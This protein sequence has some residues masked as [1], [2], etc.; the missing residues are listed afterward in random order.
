MTNFEQS[1]EKINLPE[2]EMESAMFAA[3]IESCE[4]AIIG[5]N[6]DGEILTWNKAAERIFG[7]A[8]DEVIGKNSLPQFPAERL[9]EEEEILEKVKRG[10][11]IGRYKSVRKRKDGSYISVSLN[12]SPIKNSA[13]EIIGVSEFVYELSEEKQLEENFP[14]QQLIAEAA[15]AQA[16]KTLQESEERYRAFIEHSGEG[17]WRFDLIEP[18]AVGLPFDEQIEFIY[19]KSFIAECNNVK[20]R[21]HGF[22]AAEE[23]IGRPLS[24]VWKLSDED[25]INYLGKFIES[26]Y[27]LTNEEIYEKSATGDDRYFLSNLIGIV[28]NDFL[29]GAW[30][31][32]RDVTV[33]RQAR[34]IYLET[35]EQLR[36]SQKVEAIGRLAGGVAHDFNNFLAVIMLHVDM[37][38]LQLSPD[39]PLRFRI[40]E[41]KTVTNKAAAMVRQLLAFGRKQALQ[42]HP[43]ILN[44]I[45]REFIKILRPLIGE[46]IEV[47]LDL[48]A[49]LGVCFVD[50]DQMTQ[51]LMNLA[52]NARDAMPKGGVLKIATS[53]IVLEKQNLK[54]KTQ[55]V[56]DY[57]CLT[58]S[59]SGGGMKP[60]TKKHIFEPFFTTKEPN[61]GTGLGLAT[62][63][64]VIKQSNGFIWVE[65]EPGAGATFELQ[66]PR[67]DQKAKSLVKEEKSKMQTGSETILLVEDA[68][69]VRRAAV[70]VL[71]VLGYRVFEA[72]NGEQAIHIAELMEEP[73][74]LLLTDIVMPR[75]NG[76]ELAEQIKIRHPETAVLYMSGYDDDIV[77]DQGVLGEDVHFLNKPFSPL[78]LAD[79]VR[80]VLDK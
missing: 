12:I 20:A 40:E 72:G 53:N 36:R 52:I 69:P 7:Y 41:I 43:V 59:D 44:Q 5:K 71:N 24:E 50:P 76:R 75:M 65:S 17:V 39:S 46:D 38:N 3:I 28:E 51:V 58:V 13:G 49:D 4:N 64:G 80:S 29:T 22:A 66:F 42:P 57:I 10:E 73:I 26:G 31:V 19:H 9:E 14:R 27:E 33:L 79:K 68:A 8:A 11:Q 2:A 25:R 32:Q 35:E 23:L 63:Y 74:H 78:T 6:F 37:L 15:H 56:G 55:S 70:E 48:A 21:Q 47:E 61:K 60:E 54:L 1:T 16:E 62:V 18:V 45:V 30:S 77:S 34:Q 67:I